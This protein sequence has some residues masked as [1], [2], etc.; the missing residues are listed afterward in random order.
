MNAFVRHFLLPSFNARHKKKIS[1]LSVNV[2]SERFHIAF[3][4]TN[5]VALEA[6]YL[7]RCE[8]K[9]NSPERYFVKKRGDYQIYA[10]GVRLRR[11]DSQKL[12]A[13]LTRS[14]TRKRDTAL[15]YVLPN[16]LGSPSDS[17][18]VPNDEQ[19]GGQQESKYELFLTRDWIGV[20]AA[21][22]RAATLRRRKKQNKKGNKNLFIRRTICHVLSDCQRNEGTNQRSTQR[23]PC[24][25]KKRGMVQ[26]I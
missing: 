14:I 26:K 6:G 18:V 2:A 12:D 1:S 13:K 23:K 24:C 5:A 25:E 16:H 3:T 21:E 8:R 7:I 9:S 11:N 17:I 19:T 22:T 10:A 4:A 15:D 20:T